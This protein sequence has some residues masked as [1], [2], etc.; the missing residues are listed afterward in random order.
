[1]S[2]LPNERLRARQ[3]AED[4]RCS[5]QFFEAAVQYLTARQAEMTLERAEWNNGLFQTNANLV[6]SAVRGAEIARRNL[7]R[8]ESPGRIEG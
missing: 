5:L 8:L 6:A 1:V 2:E 3:E 7:A 4:W